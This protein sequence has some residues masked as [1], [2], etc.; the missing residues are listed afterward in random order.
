MNT[1]V[2]RLIGWV[3][4]GAL[5]AC[6]SLQATTP[7]MATWPMTRV[8]M[9]TEL[10]S[11]ARPAMVAAA[12]QM[13]WTQ[14]P[15]VKIHI[16]CQHYTWYVRTTHGRLSSSG[17]PEHSANLCP[18]QTSWAPLFTT[19]LSRMTHYRIEGHRLILSNTR[20]ETIHFVAADWD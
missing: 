20:G 10:D 2:T 19:R 3:A 12:A 6:H 16:G 18:A 11:I 17:I 8:W 1:T 15:Q 4:I 5:S 7:T 9:L 13:D 14:L